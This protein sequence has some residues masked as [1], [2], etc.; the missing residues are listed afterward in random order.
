VEK[1]DGKRSEEEGGPEHAVESEAQW[2]EDGAGGMVEKA[3]GRR[4]RV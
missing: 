2:R 3:D 1:A 4:D